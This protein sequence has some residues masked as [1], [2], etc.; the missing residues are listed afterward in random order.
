MA[1]V[2]KKHTIDKIVKSTKFKDYMERIEL[3][4]QGNYSALLELKT[5]TVKKQER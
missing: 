4:N 2:N 5:R 1:V 3:A